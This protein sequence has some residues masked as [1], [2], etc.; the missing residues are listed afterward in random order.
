MHVWE[1]DVCGGGGGDVCGG[2]NVWGGGDAYGG[3]DVGGEGD[4]DGGGDVCGEGMRVG[5]KR[6]TWGH[7]CAQSSTPY[8]VPLAAYSHTLD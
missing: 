4:V 2:G 8:T 1:E 5:D 7:T 3:G 6:S